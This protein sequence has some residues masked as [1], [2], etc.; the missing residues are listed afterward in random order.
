MDKKGELM[1]NDSWSLGGISILCL[2]LLVSSALGT[3]LFSPSTS[4]LFT[5]Y[6]YDS[7]MFQTIGKYWT[8]GYLP[9]ADLFDHKGPVIFFINALGYLLGERVGVFILQ[10][11]S[12]FISELLAYATLRRCMG[13]NASMALAFLLPL[14]L[15]MNW[16]EGNTTEEYI[17]PLL[18]ACYYLM[19][20]WLEDRESGRDEHKPTW[21]FIYGLCFGFA[22]MSRVTNALGVCVGVAFISAYL[23][24]MRKWKNL[25]KNSLFFILG[26]LSLVLPFC[27][28]FWYHG[29]LYEMWYGTL[30]F[31]FKYFSSSGMERPEGLVAL[32]SAVRTYFTGWCLVAAAVWSLAAAKGKRFDACFWLAISLVNTLF[33]YTLN[34]YAHYGIVLMPFFY[35]ALILMNRT[36]YGKHIGAAASF[37]A[38]AMLALLLASSGLKAYKSLTVYVPPQAYEDIVDYGDDYSE[39]VSMVPEEDRDSFVAFNCYRSLYLENDIRPAFRFFVLQQWMIS[40]S[41]ELEKQM[42]MEFNEADIKW[43][44]SFEPDGANGYVREM[45]GDDYVCVAG[46]EH[47]AYRLYCRKTD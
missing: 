42:T 26:V 7:A 6:G 27:I 44:L 24:V 33:I 41:P 15:V 19:L 22:L 45:L 38:F 23:A 20:R 5:G 11:C 21:A 9:Y 40:N 8:Q 16:Q 18:F 35:L 12:C 4:P 2:L 39:L 47:Q 46:T 32:L 14:L 31:N 29:D 28:Y 17:L 36:D 3:A 13:K 34:N 25:L 30:L 1:N 37:F 10:V 43:V